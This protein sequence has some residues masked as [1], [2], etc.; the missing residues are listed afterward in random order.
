M[1]VVI[2]S[3]TYVNVKADV[4]FKGAWGDQGDGT[5][6]NPI[7]PGDYSDLD[8][9]RVG[10][11]YYMISSTMQLSPG[12][13]VLHS[14]DLVNWEII[15]HVVNDMTQISESYNYTRMDGYGRGIWAGAIRYHDNKF[16]V[17]FGVPE[18][19]YFMSTATNP[20]GPWEPLTRVTMDNDPN[21]PGA[22]WNDC[23]P[24]WDDDGQ[25]YFVGTN[26]YDG[27]KIHLFKMSEDGKKLIS[28]SDTVIHQESGSEA[29]KIYKINGYYYFF[30]SETTTGRRNVYMLRSKNIFGDGGSP[31][32]AGTY[33]HKCVIQSIGNDR[34]PNQGGLVQT[35]DGS[36]YFVTHHGSMSLEGRPVSLLPISWVDD[37]P[38]LGVDSNNDGIG[39]MVWSGTKPINGYPI[40]FP[41]SSDDFESLTLSPQWEWNY[42]PRAD[43]W[44]LSERP[45]YL[46][47]HAFKPLS[48]DN[49]FKAGNTISQRFMRTDFGVATTKIDIGNMA[50]GQEAGL[51]HFDGGSRYCTIG[52]VQKNGVKYF[53]YREY[54]NGPD[55][56]GPEIS[57]SATTVWFKSIMNNSQNIAFMYSL[58]GKNFTQLGGTYNLSGANYRGNRIG[59]Y[60]YN[61]EAESGYVDVDWFDYRYNEKPI[62][63][64]SKIEAESFTA[65]SGNIEVE[66]CSDVEKGQN[67]VVTG[68]DG[69]TS[70]SNIDFASGAAMISVRVAGTSPGS[71]EVR[72]DGPSGKLLG[73]ISVPS[74]DGEQVWQ[75]VTA[76]I[77]RVTGIHDLYL[78]YKTDG[79]FNVNWFEFSES[80]SSIKP[81]P[82]LQYLFD[83]DVN[84]STENKNHGILHKGVGL[85]TASFVFDS[86]FG[87]VLSLP[88]G[89]NGNYV[90]IPGDVL[91]GTDSITVTGWI[92]VNSSA[93]YQRFFDFGIND[94]KYLFCMPTETYNTK[95]SIN[96]YI[97][98]AEQGVTV[99]PIP[100]NEWHHLAVVLDSAN[101]TMRVYLDGV[102]VG[103][104]TNVTLGISQIIDQDPSKN[105]FY[106][107][108]SQYGSDPELNG[109]LYDFRI[110]DTP[111]SSAQVREVMNEANNSIKPV[112]DINTTFNLDELKPG[113]TI[114]ANVSVTNIKSSIK[115]VMAIVALYDENDRMIN[116]SYNSRS[117]SVGKTE[118]LRAGFR[119]PP[120][121]DGY[122]VKVFVWDGTDLSKTNMIPLSDVVILD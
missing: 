106:I 63:A 22:G 50:N 51:T 114:D 119:L 100:L 55:I 78:V 14:K 85:P 15:G 39:E 70:Y 91:Y 20:A 57:S 41:Q 17:Y 29:N 33:E 88:G 115:S 72:V 9:I 30:H 32:K 83:G 120:N 105:F 28:S 13:V 27:Y 102:L 5:Y 18:V 34:E 37:W 79:N 24:F 97:N 86:K 36:W 69:Y 98:G 43:K 65:Q 121:T 99:D 62:D 6:I 95:I 122:K 64:F 87:T 108:K 74:T 109:K 23:C 107:G 54:P 1:L 60:C 16:W 8:V 25:G 46:R 66:S 67:I 4:G 92:Y 48:T 56:L 104:N 11:D 53:R 47:L 76:N 58:D 10:S 93:N 112:F 82:I 113:N 12:M 45:G 81:N 3:L 80:T 40:K 44:S 73:S 77:E 19:G 110:Y 84:D 103:Y 116:M 31:G 75:T 117:I 96:S 59:I 94:K 118:N 49:L 61:N 90:Q 68:N 89:K 71:I 52:V 42:Q 2:I 101:T 7:I 26:F 38:I 35:E 21:F 111:L